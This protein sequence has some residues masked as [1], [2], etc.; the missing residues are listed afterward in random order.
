MHTSEK[1]RRTYVVIGNSE[2][3]GVVYAERSGQSGRVSA[4][5]TRC[6]LELACR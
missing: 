4:S 6:R 1:M 2:W 5:W 3:W